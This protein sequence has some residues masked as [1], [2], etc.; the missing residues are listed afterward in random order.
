[1]ANRTPIVLLQ[2]VQRSL[3]GFENGELNSYRGSATLT[4]PGAT[5]YVEGNTSYA[6][7]MLIIR[8]SDVRRLVVHG[9]ATSVLLK[10][11]QRILDDP[12]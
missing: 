7:T 6:T 2:D 8:E 11:I 5:L 1:M 12:T 10:R 3:R 9:V 4:V